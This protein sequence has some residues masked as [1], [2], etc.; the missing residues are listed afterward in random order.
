MDREHGGSDGYGSSDK[1]F[2]TGELRSKDKPFQDRRISFGT[3]GA[4]PVFPNT[5]IRTEIPR[6]SYCFGTS[7][8][9]PN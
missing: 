6:L 9:L 8:S 3:T 7:K 2:E 5:E 4:V 1:M